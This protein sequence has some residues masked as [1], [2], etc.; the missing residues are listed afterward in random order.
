MTF[1]VYKRGVLSRVAHDLQLSIAQVTLKIDGDRVSGSIPMNSFTVDGFLTGGS[2]DTGSV[3]IK[4]AADIL[5]KVRTIVL[6]SDDHPTAQLEGE[7]DR[8]SS[9][10]KGRLTLRGRTA[11]IN[12]PVKGSVGSYEGT[13]EITPTRWGIAPYKALFGAI[14]LQDRVDIGFQFCAS[15]RIR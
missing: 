5:K 12:T 14:Q 11:E 4:D 2:V 8:E 3:S 15:E 7:L 10:F 6:C 9:V 13:I 1:R